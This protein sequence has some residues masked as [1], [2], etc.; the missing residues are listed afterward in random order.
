[1]TA[2]EIAK[3][4]FECGLAPHSDITEEWIEK[5]IEKYADKKV[6]EYGKYIFGIYFA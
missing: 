1:M 5:E 2:K 6:Y 4:I 3:A